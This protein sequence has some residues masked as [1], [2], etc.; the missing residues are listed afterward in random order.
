MHAFDRQEFLK[1]TRVSGAH[2]GASETA[3][4]HRWRQEQVGR[5][6]PGKLTE[7]R[8]PRPGVSG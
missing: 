7:G 8:P 1:W 3:A 6:R 4:Q 5:G 2:E